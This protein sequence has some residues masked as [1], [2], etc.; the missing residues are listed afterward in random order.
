MKQQHNVVMLYWLPSGV[1][2]LDN[3]FDKVSLGDD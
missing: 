3:H 2:T 1:R